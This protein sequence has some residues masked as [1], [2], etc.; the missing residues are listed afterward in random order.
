[1]VRLAFESIIPS[2]A[3]LI[4][5]DAAAV[6]ADAALLEGEVRLGDA[7]LRQLV[8]ASMFICVEATAIHRGFDRERVR[9]LLVDSIFA[10]REYPMLDRRNAVMLADDFANHPVIRD[11]D[12]LAF[13]DWICEA[14]WSHFQTIPYQ[15]PS[16][17]SGVIAQVL[18]IAGALEKVE[19]EIDESAAR[20]FQERL[21]RMK[22]E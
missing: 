20:E 18:R 7:E 11:D 12:D 15:Y 16:A 9:P 4:I 21:D 22:Q 13:E 14:L 19:L 6:H 1:M 17:T 8:L 3:P 10:L 2:F 5:A